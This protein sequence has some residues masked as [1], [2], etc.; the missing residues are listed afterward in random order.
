MRGASAF[1]MA[2]RRDE[3]AS[4]VH[5]QPSAQGLSKHRAGSVGRN[6]RDRHI[7]GRTA[8]LIDAPR[9]CRG[10]GRAANAG[11]RLLRQTAR[12]AA[13]ALAAGNDARSRSFRAGQRP[14]R[15]RFVARAWRGRAATS[16]V[17]AFESDELEAN[18]WSCS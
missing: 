3:R 13:L 7:A 1:C 17:H 18:G 12:S 14:G 8:I 4:A 6:L 16:P 11:C 5:A 9:D 15:R 10:T 2:R